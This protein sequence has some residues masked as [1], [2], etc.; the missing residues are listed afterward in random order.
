[1]RQFLA[2]LQDFLERFAF[3]VLHDQV[4]Q[5]FGLA[6]LK[7]ADDVGM[8]ETL[9]QAGLALEAAEGLGVLDSGRRQHL[10]G[11]HLAEAMDSLVNAGHASGADAVEELVL[12]EEET[13]AVAAQHDA[14]LV[15]GEVVVRGQPA[16]KVLNAAG[17]WAGLAAPALGQGE[18][19]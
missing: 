10:D 4:V 17:R 1:G 7:G 11:D 8:S 12:I 2:A 13:A 5:A 6:D 3:E 14:G 16:D 15:F 19:L 9:G 18:S